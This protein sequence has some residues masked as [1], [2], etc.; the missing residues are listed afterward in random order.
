MA[1]LCVLFEDLRIEMGG[2]NAVE[3]PSMDEI[4][5]DSRRLYFMRRSLGTLFEFS[6][7]I[8][9][10]ERLPEFGEIR[11]SF[12][13][14]DAVS[15]RRAVRFFSQNHSRIAR[16]R[17]HIGGHFGQQAA[18]HAIDTFGSTECGSITITLN[19][20]RT[21]GAILSFSQVVAATAFG[22]NV[23]GATTERT[24][25]DFA[26]RTIVGYRHAVRAVDCLVASYLWDRFGR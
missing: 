18:E 24:G 25:R 15:W 8:A 5:R 14:A 16:L 17:H 3:I 21:G 11:S 2:I 1:R 6:E 26:M 23:G 4:D 7:A 20:D 19:P 12:D 10:L 22:V 9:G 13:P